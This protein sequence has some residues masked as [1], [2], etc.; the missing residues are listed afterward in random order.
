MQVRIGIDGCELRTQSMERQLLA[1]GFVAVRILQ[2][3][4]PAN[5]KV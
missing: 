1:L 2:R 5:A 4:V 3:Y